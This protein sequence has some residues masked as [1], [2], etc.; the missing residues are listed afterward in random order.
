MTYAQFLLLFL[1]IPIVVLCAVTRR[2]LRSRHLLAC[3]VVCLLAFLYTAPWDN[4]AAKIG[5]WSFDSHFAPPSHFILYLPWEEYAFYGLQ[6]VFVCLLVVAL[7]R[8]L[9]PRNG[10]EL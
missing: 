9:R 2:L 4:H 8:F 3:A 7:S 1:L 5:L 10:G 6:G